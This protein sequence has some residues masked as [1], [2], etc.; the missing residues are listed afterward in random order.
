MAAWTVGIVVA[1]CGDGGTAQL[2]PAA[3]ATAGAAIKVVARMRFRMQ[4]SFP[5]GNLT[6]SDANGTSHFF[7]APDCLGAATGCVQGEPDTLSYRRPCRHRGRQSHDALSR[8]S[9]IRHQPDRTS[10]S[11]G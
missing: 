7:V 8:G 3:S 4:G 9:A 6:P 5:P 11:F 2:G 10:R 1:S